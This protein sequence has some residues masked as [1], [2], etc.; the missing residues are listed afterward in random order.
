VINLN[1]V[2]YKK[3]ESEGREKAREKEILDYT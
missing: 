1:L 2:K 3:K